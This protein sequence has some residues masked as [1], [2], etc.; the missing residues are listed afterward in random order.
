VESNQKGIEEWLNTELE[1]K[2]FLVANHLTLADL[3][4]FGSMI[5]LVVNINSFIHTLVL[6][7]RLPQSRVMQSVQ[8]V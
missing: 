8:M 3:V 2:T 4:A 5:D 7:G 6:D 1:H